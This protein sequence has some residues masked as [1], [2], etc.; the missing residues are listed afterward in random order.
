MAAPG[1]PLRLRGVLLT[2]RTF[3]GENR[4]TG[5]AGFRPEC[6]ATRHGSPYCS[7]ADA[8]YSAVPSVGFRLPIIQIA[9]ARHTFRFQVGD[10]VFQAFLGRSL[11]H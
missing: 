4:L 8:A 7:A 2:S 3:R 5:L 6:V 10:V 1:P 9:V 11:R